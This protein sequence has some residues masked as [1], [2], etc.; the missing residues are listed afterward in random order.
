MWL[1]QVQKQERQKIKEASF[2]ERLAILEHRR[3]Y[4][5]KQKH[6]LDLKIADLHARMAATNISD[7]GKEAEAGR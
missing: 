4:L 2:D 5:F 1:T 3:A 7:G 6:D